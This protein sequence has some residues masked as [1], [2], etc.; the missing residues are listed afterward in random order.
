MD[1]F[2][3]LALSILFRILTHGYGFQNT[4][5]AAVGNSRPI[6]KE[7]PHLLCV[8]T[9][10]S[11]LENSSDFKHCFGLEVEAAVEPGHRVKSS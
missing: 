8:K 1:K 3:A 10:G 4:R 6:Y 11:C 9:P 5:R 2:S 7:R